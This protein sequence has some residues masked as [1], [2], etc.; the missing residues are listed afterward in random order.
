MA[1]T[2]IEETSCDWHAAIESAHVAATQIQRLTNPRNGKTHEVDLCDLC[3]YVWD[4]LN[5]PT[6]RVRLAALDRLFT[7]TR[8]VDRQPAKPPARV[9]KAIAAEAAPPA[10]LTETDGIGQLAIVPPLH[11]PAPA[12]PEGRLHVV[13]QDCQPPRR[14]A[15]PGRKDHARAVHAT[16]P[17]KI[18]WL[19]EDGS[20]LPYPCK[21]HDECDQTGYAF[22]TPQSRGYHENQPLPPAP[23]PETGGVRRKINKPKNKLKPKKW[24]KQGPN[25]TWN[26]DLEQVG[27]S[28]DHPKQPGAPKPYWVQYKGRSSHADMAHDGAKVWEIEWVVPDDGSI[29]LP[30]PCT[31]HKECRRTGLAFKSETGLR[32]HIT[33]HDPNSA[34]RLSAIA[35]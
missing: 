25:G 22:T 7:L 12:Q 19:M 27:C 2:V 4:I 20:G 30:H 15:Y 21:K 17:H 33:G 34:R 35:G 8:T 28:L 18:V 11:K 6:V 24:T 3:A 9:Q 16:L 5:E 14:I 10:P 29:E 13:C 26:P 31:V 32:I 23:E 1:R